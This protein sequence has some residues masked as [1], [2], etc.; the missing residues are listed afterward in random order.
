[1][2]RR[3]I[4]ELVGTREIAERLGLAHP[5]SVH[6]WRRRHADFPEPVASLGIGLVWSWPEVRE[7]AVRTG[8][9]ILNEGGRR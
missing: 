6:A 3:E 5:E 9:P 8:R 4:P 7:W 2:P 1:M